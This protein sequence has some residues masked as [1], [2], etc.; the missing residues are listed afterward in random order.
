MKKGSGSGGASKKWERWSKKWVWRRTT[1]V[2]VVV[3]EAGAVVR[4]VEK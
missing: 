3:Q 2:G 1:E 4:E